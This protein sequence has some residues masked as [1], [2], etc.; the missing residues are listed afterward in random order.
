MKVAKSHNMFNFESQWIFFVTDTNS[1]SF[2]MSKYINMAQDGYNLAF[3]FNTSIAVE[4]AVCP[5]GL[6]CMVGSLV[7]YIGKC[8][9]KVVQIELETFNQ[10][11]IE[12][13]DIVAPTPEERAIAIIDDIK[14]NEVNLI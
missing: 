8:F 13:W 5:S 12:E 7:T 14:V 1:L 3:V 2:D 6:E 10:I 9:E 11:S 4:N